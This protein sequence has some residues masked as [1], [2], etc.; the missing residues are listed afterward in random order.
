MS[1][2]FSACLEMKEFDSEMLNLVSINFFL[3]FVAEI[4]FNIHIKSRLVETRAD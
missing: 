2:P 4:L 1:I 3:L